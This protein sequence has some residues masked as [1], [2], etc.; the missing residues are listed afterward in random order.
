[1]NGRKLLLDA[2]KILR[3][4]KYKKIL[5]NLISDPQ[6]G[7]ISGSNRSSAPRS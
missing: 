3:G 4:K 1:M 2:V 6:L 5:N 7:N